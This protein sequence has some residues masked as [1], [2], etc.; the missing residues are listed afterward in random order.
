M[1]PCV[2]ICRH[3]LE[4]IGTR[5]PKCA[6]SNWTRIALGDTARLALEFSFLPRLFCSFFIFLSTFRRDYAARRDT[7]EWI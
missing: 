7:L 2:E 3:I 5:W 6:T 4:T 1:K